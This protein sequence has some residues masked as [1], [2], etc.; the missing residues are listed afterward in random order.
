MPFQNAG[1]IDLHQIGQCRIQQ[2]RVVIAKAG[3]RGARQLPRLDVGEPVA[4]E[5]FFFAE[6]ALW[7]EGAGAL[8]VS[9]PRRVF[10][11]AQFGCERLEERL[12]VAL[13][14]PL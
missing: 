12:A 9:A 3:E 10:V 14:R 4:R 7:P 13:E 11:G 5:R 8:L 2:A 6:K 1:E